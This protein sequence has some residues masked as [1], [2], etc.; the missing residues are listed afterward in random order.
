MLYPIDIDWATFKAGE[1]LNFVE[2]YYQIPYYQLDYET[3]ADTVLANFRL[4][5]LLRSLETKDSLSDS[6]IRRAVL[7]PAP[8]PFKNAARRDLSFVDGFGFYARSGKY[9]YQIKFKSKIQSDTMSIPDLI[10]KP[11]LSGLII[12]N[13]IIPDTTPSIIEKFEKGGF[14]ILP[15][16]SRVFVP[17]SKIARG[18]EIGVYF[19]GY[20]LL[21]DTGFY[22]VGYSILSPGEEMKDSLTVVKTFP[23]KRKKKTG[24]NLFEAFL[25]SSKGLRPGRYLLSVTLSDLST[26]K[27]AESYKEFFIGLPKTKTTESTYAGRVR[28]VDTIIHRSGLER[29]GYVDEKFSTARVKGRDTDRGRIYLKYG[30]PDVTESHTMLEHTRPHE[31]WYYYNQGFHFI[32]VDI[33]GDGNYLLVYSNTP[34]ERCHP[35]WEKYVDPLELEDLR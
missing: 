21:P 9:S 6:L 23:P 32:F 10:S 33:F 1:D 5:F 25:L 4:D 13:R 28:K 7:P 8:E 29:A 35:N 15:N 27:R 3:K 17:E 12:A 31:H 18:E 30:P 2:V 16:P 11:S 26:N 24:T 20:N 22:E 14:L 34:Q 19:E